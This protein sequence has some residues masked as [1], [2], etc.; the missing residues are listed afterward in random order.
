MYN[1]YIPGQN[2]VYRRQIIPEPQPEPKDESTQQTPLFTQAQ[3]VSIPTQNAAT[4]KSRLPFSLDR[5][6]P[7][8][9]E[10]GDLLVL[11]ILLLIL[12]DGETDDPLPI[13]LMIAAFM[14]L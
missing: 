7:Q 9:L 3:A 1:R 4:G 12:V 5:L 2:G 6:L 14:F 11:L 8:K 10:T 13:L